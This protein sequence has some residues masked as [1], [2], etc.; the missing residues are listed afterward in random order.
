MHWR[1]LFFL[2]LLLAATTVWRVRAASESLW[3]DE[4]HSA[5]CAG[6]TLREVAPRAAIGNQSPLYFWLL[7]ALSQW[8]TPSELA[9]RG[10][11]IIAGALLLVAIY[12]IAASWLRSPWLGLLAAWLVAMEPA[13]GY[14]SYYATEVRP[15][16]LV[17]LLATLHVW[18]FARLCRRPTWPL[19]AAFILGAALLF[20]LH[21]TAALLL[22]AEL[23]F[24]FIARVR[25]LLPVHYS[26]RQLTLDLALIGISWLPAATTVGNIFSRRQNWALFVEQAPLVDSFEQLSWSIAALLVLAA[27]L[28][29]RYLIE[30]P[31]GR[32]GP[33]PEQ[34][35]LRQFAI[36][37]LC[38]LLVPMGLA[39][40]AT[41]RDVA[42]LFFARYLVASMPAAILL[43]VSCVRLAPCR[44]SQTLIAGL[45]AA[46][47][48][49]MNLMFDDQG[50]GEDWRSAV[51]WLNEQL[52]QQPYPV[53]LMPDLIEDQGL[54]QPHDER[55]EDYCLFPLTALYRVKTQRSDLLP[56]PSRG[57]G[58]LTGEQCHWLAARGG[59]W[60][61][62]R[63][64]AP[65]TAEE[66]AQAIA[67]ELNANPGG[68][69]VWRVKP[70]H[71][72]K[73]VQILLLSSSG[74]AL[75]L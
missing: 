48:L 8:I 55:L 54:R 60:L 35:R 7:W 19:R 53:L 63:A 65:E 1:S 17:M 25:L 68:Q 16:A 57:A 30:L 50:R 32:R 59:A 24:W 23:L 64:T 11:S 37:A 72:G 34:L 73:G 75:E 44:W 42:R 33:E 47:A 66:Q 45:L 15:Y 43:A 74:P 28:V 3:A 69:P 26:A 27:V 58:L 6:G 70:K 20:H 41:W 12:A 31:Q 10:T 67:T 62:M 21:Y 4:L 2:A 14:F 61:V 18:L 39:W 71:L 52:P 13:P 22:P 29:D 9:L 49:W 5:W 36:L 56:L 51:V 40:L 46:V 38:W